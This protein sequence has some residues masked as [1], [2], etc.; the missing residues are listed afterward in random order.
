MS[1]SKHTTL[2]QQKSSDTN[3]SSRVLGHGAFSDLS[4][5]HLWLLTELFLV[6]SKMTLWKGVSLREQK[7]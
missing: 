2:G 5:G 7:I 1:Q 4:Q 3:T 6:V